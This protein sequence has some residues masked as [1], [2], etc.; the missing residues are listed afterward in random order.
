MLRGDELNSIFEQA[1]NLIQ[2]IADYLQVPIGEIRQ[3]AADGELTADTVKAA[4]FSAADDINAKFEQMP[5]TWGQLWTSF[6]NTAV[7]AFQPVLQRLNAMANSEAFQSFVSAAVQALATVA[8]IVLNIFDLIGS[9]AGFVADNWSIISPIIYGIVG[10]LAVYA[11]YLAI[12]KGLEIASAV[13]TAVMTGAKLLASAAMVL[14][15][16]AAWGAATAQLGLNSAMYACPLVW[17]IILIIA[18]IAI[19]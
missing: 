16:G 4:I 9:V 2:N 13:A 15:T 11:A 19:I 8:N 6:T 1:P 18:L 10:A 12:V 14:F 5:M 17:I 3:M 7:M